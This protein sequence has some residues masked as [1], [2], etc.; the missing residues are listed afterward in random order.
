MSDE[1][2]WLTRLSPAEWLSAA[3][4]ELTLARTTLQRR[5][6]RPAVTHARRAAGMALNAILRTLP[7]DDPRHARWGRSYMEH[8]AALAAD[9][10]A[11]ENAG[12]AARAL[13]QTPPVAPE[14]LQIGRPDTTVADAAALLIAFARRHVDADASHES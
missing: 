9:P 11:P 12:A 13:V 2:E 3:A 1:N 10:A 14:L 7:P 8:L 6:F 5:A 4:H